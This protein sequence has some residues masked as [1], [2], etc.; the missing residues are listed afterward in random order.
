MIDSNAGLLQN[1]EDAQVLHL[2]R[3]RGIISASQYL[4]LYRDVRKENFEA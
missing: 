4:E 2:A 1:K 3:L